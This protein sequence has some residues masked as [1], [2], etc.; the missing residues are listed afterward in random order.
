MKRDP[1]LIRKILFEVEKCPADKHI[2]G[3]E[4]DDYDEHTVA[5]HTELLIEAGLLD[6]EV[7]HFISGEP[8]SVIVRRLTWSGYDFVDAVRDDTVWKKVR[9]NVLKPSASWT[10]GLLI[11][12]AK[13]E[14]RKRLGI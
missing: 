3:F 12:Y 8:P 9:E 11:E 7:T 10:F 13:A 14:I 2:N 5:L 4:F 1:E 6:G